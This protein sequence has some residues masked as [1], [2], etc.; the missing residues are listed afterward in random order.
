MYKYIIL[1]FALCSNLYAIKPDTVI[2]GVNTCRF[3]VPYADETVEFIKVGTATAKKP[4]LLFCQGSLPIPLVIEFND[5]ARMITGI[6]NFNY[7]LLAQRFHIIEVS[8]PFIP[9][10]AKEGDLNNQFAYITDKT[11]NHSYPQTYTN[12]NNLDYHAKRLNSV[13]DYLLNQDWVDNEHIFVVGHSQGARVATELACSNTAINAIALLS[14]NPMG[15]ITQ[16]IQKCNIDYLN[17]KITAEEK[18]NELNRIYTFY[19]SASDNID[20]PSS[21]GED[22]NKNIISYSKPLANKLA[23]LSIPVFIGYGTADPGTW[24]CDYLPLDF[25]AAGKENYI[26]KPYIGLNHNFMPVDQDGKVHYEECKWDEV[27][28][29]AIGFITR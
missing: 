24:Y 29:D 10:I 4:V 12:C 21:E 5:G 27:M 26:V 19:K 28:A 15:R 11:D 16:S 3:A 20:K 7:E 23:Q 6:S 18:Q 2:E 13:I 22:S 14:C 25:I 1:L 17:G 8:P 9:L